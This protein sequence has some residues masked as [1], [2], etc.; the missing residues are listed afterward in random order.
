[1]TNY[2]SQFFSKVALGQHFMDIV[3]CI[4][5][6]I[7]EFFKKGHKDSKRQWKK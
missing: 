4:H 1:M 2:K 5:P 7:F 6:Q 3:M